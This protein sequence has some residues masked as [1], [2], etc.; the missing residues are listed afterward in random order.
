[1]FYNYCDNPD[2]EVP[3]MFLDQMIGKDD[4]MPYEP[5]IDG[6]RFAREIYALADSG[7]K[8][9]N[10]IINSPGG[11]V[12]EGMKIYDA[13]LNAPTN[14]NTHCVFAASMAAAC[15]MA[16]KK[17]TMA[18]YAQLMF[19]PVGGSE[20]MKAME[21]ITDS[22][23]MM[24][25]SRCEMDDDQIKQMMRRT[26]WIGADEALEMKLCHEVVGSGTKNKPRLTGDIKS[27]WN[28]AKSIHNNALKQIKE[29]KNIANLLGLA[30]DATEEQC[31]NAISDLMKKA[32]NGKVFTNADDTNA[33]SIANI[34]DIVNK[35]VV[36]ATAPLVADLTAM[37]NKET[38]AIQA[39]ATMKATALVEKYVNR[40]G[41]ATATA[42]AKSA[43][44]N[45]AVA[46]YAETEKMLEA[47][48]VNATAFKIEQKEEPATLK[49]TYNAATIMNR[50]AVANKQIPTYS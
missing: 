41:G 25:A 14:V 33:L 18:D 4:S 26:T 10:I 32:Q 3:V 17:R 48:P 46:D 50:I 30:D 35:A 27:M 7:K 24:T 8:T 42:E 11:L 47:L 45:K 15:F 31:S 16:G 23:A 40:L 28:Q 1:M 49:G 44:V 9:V 39:A 19:H 21:A 2:A 36:A 5:F 29:M 22:V 12:T 6:S 20:D 34:A 13:I 37:K 38:E 43:W